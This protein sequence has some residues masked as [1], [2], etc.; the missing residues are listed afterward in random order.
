MEIEHFPDAI[1]ADS[2]QLV[3][4]ISPTRVLECSIDEQSH[5]LGQPILFSFEMTFARLKVP[6][7]PCQDLELNQMTKAAL[8]RRT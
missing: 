6:S 5:S 7:W 3:R 4:Y 8:Y 1:I 2:C